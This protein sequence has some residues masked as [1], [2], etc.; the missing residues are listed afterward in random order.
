MNN[1]KTE[2]I[3]VFD[4]HKGKSRIVTKNKPYNRLI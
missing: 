3:Y 1:E 4:V 2:T